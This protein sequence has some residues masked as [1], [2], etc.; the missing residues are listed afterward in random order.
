MFNS[1]IACNIPI[2]DVGFI[3]AIAL[4]DVPTCIDAS[5]NTGKEYYAALQTDLKHCLPLFKS[6]ITT[7]DAQ[8][9]CLLALENYRLVSENSLFNTNILVRVVEYLYHENVLDEEIIL[10]WHQEPQPFPEIFR[11]IENGR[12]NRLR[13]ERALKDFAQWLLEAE[14]ESDESE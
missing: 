11:P 2:G 8:R 9:D 10:R 7:K 4:L 3:L 14:E 6:Y 1:R 12:R 13:Q 5:L